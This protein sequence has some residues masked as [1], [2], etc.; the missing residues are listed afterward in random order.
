MTEPFIRK[1]I[2]VAAG[3][4]VSFSAALWLLSLPVEPPAGTLARFG[5][6]SALVCAL[7]SIGYCWA[8]SLVYIARRHHWSPRKCSQAAMSII[9]VIVVLACFASPRARTFTVLLTG[10]LPMIT[11][12]LCV[13]RVY[14]E[15]TYDEA[16]APEPPLSLFPK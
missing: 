3:F 1:K 12:Y 16:V 13:R 15:L 4:L 7:G 2:A 8:V 14:P 6:A 10:F 11:G 9:A 5:F